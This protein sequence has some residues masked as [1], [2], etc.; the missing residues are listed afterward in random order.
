MAKQRDRLGAF[1]TQPHRRSQRFL[2]LGKVIPVQQ[3][4]RLHQRHQ[5][6]RWI[7][8]PRLGKRGHKPAKVGFGR[9]RARQPVIHRARSHRLGQVKRRRRFAAAHNLHRTGG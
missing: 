7:K 4:L 9:C 1:H 2:R 6:L 3:N 5:R 8:P